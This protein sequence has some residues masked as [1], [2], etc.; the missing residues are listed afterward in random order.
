MFTD[1]KLA[2]F[3]LETSATKKGNVELKPGTYTFYCNVTGHRAAG[4]QA[5]LTVSAS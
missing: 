3:E 1:P 5:T 2:G 4:M